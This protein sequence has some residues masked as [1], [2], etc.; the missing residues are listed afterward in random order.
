LKNV[1][2]RAWLKSEKEGVLGETKDGTG[3]E[4]TKWAGKRKKSSR[5][6]AYVKK[7][8]H[9]GAVIGGQS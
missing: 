1:E 5:V 4:E 7:T 8:K 9:L 6:K 3:T 2:K